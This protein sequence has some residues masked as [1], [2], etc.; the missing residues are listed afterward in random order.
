[1]FDSIFQK[2]MKLVQ[3]NNHRCMENDISTRKVYVTQCKQNYDD[4]KWIVENFNS[5][6]STWSLTY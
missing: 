4:Q 2:K 1:M 5:Q 3:G 6:S